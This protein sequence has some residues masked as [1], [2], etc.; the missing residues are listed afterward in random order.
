[1]GAWET[2]TLIPNGDGTI[3]LRSAA[4]SRLVTAEAAGGAPL[5]ANRTAIGVW[6]MFDMVGS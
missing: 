2:Y 5:I 4:N 3:S 6:E 1:V